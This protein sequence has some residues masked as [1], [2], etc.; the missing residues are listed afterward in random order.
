MLN[1]EE[2]AEAQAQ[3]GFDFGEAVRLLKDGY[4]VYRDGWNGKGMY[5]YHV[6]ADAYPAKTDIAKREF[7]EEGKVPYRAY[8]AMLTAQGDV[9]PW[10]ASQS[11]VLATDWQVIIPEAPQADT[12]MNQCSQPVQLGAAAGY[13]PSFERMRALEM[14]IGLCSSGNVPDGTDPVQLAGRFMTFINGE[15]K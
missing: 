10:V 4:A 7:G 6:G 11:D 13:P 1:E 3:V 12:D 9:V 8:I 5:L 15:A 2:T 14:A